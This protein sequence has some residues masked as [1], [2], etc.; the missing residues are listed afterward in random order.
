MSGFGVRSLHQIFR[1]AIIQFAVKGDASA[2]FYQNAQ[3]IGSAA[4]EEIKRRMQDVFY[5]PSLETAKEHTAKVL[6]DCQEAH[7]A[8]CVTSRMAHTQRLTT[9]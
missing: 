8:R 1:C 3:S 2:V 5:A 4:N 7:L 9:R 6:R